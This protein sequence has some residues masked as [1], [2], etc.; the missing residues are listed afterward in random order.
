[1]ITIEIVVT[2]VILE[3]LILGMIIY[4]SCKKENIKTNELNLDHIENITYLDCPICY[5]EFNQ[6][7]KISILVCDHYYHEECIKKWINSPLLDKQYRNVKKA[8][9]LCRED[10]IFKSNKQTD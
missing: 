10:L 1:M 2:F 7:D 9:P 3:K 6:Q 5:E 8:C 4:N